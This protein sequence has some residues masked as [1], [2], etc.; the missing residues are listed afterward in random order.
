MVDGCRRDR[1]DCASK[2]GLYRMPRYAVTNFVACVETNDSFNLMIAGRGQRGTVTKI[3]KEGSG[4]FYRFRCTWTVSAVT[5]SIYLYSRPSPA[6]SSEKAIVWAEMDRGVL[7]GGRVQFLG[8]GL[9]RGHGPATWWR[10]HRVEAKAG[11][12]WYNSVAAAWHFVTAARTTTAHR[13][14]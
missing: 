8:L 5:L 2:T 1:L 13:L 11:L 10:C 9:F 4:H 3:G 6:A 12:S 14:P 7:A